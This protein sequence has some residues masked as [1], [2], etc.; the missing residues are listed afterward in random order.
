MWTENNYEGL[1]PFEP[2]V[3]RW[4]IFSEEI[5]EDGTPH[6]QGY[7]YFKNALTME[8]AKQW[9]KGR[10]HLEPRRGTHAQAKEYCS[11]TEDP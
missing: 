4:Q 9:L 3:M 7:T 8:S 6:L 1:M 2:Q 11:K 10:V 5:G